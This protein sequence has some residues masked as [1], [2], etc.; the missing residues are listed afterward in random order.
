MTQVISPPS[1]TESIILGCMLSNTEYL[2]LGSDRLEE[3]DFQDP[4]HRIIY[5]IL[6]RLFDSNRPADVHLV[7]K[8]LENIGKLNA[9][10]GP[11]YIASLSQYAGTSAHFEEYISVLK[12]MS[13]KRNLASM[14]QDIFRLSTDKYSSNPCFITICLVRVCKLSDEFESDKYGEI[15]KEAFIVHTR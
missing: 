12:E 15:L 11:V 4:N 2:E 8:E 9:V 7:C 5:S 6:K 3:D 1:S 13:T 10:G 14:G